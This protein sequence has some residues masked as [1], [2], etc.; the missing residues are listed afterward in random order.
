MQIDDL[1]RAHPQIKVDDQ[2]FEWLMENQEDAMDLE[3]V[4]GPTEGS[5]TV[6]CMTR[7]GIWKIAIWDPLRKKLI[8]PGEPT[9]SS[10]KARLE[11]IEPLDPSERILHRER[12][13]K[14]AKE[15]DADIEVVEPAAWGRAWSMAYDLSAQYPEI[16]VNR[17]FCNRLDKLLTDPQA[18]Y[19]LVGE[20]HPSITS[21]LILLVKG[22]TT[23]A[24]AAWNPGRQDFSYMRE[25][26]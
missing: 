7:C 3:G 24:F 6:Q 15:L 11:Y 12:M 21:T 19:E 16:P 5:I 13:E 8:Y 9:S 14:L 17:E 22:D 25:D 2:L 23:I 1:K 20:T 18:E 26:D 10:S 4:P